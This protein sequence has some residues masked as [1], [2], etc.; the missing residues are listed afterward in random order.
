MTQKKQETKK[1]AGPE[2]KEINDSAVNS[3]TDNEMNALLA[4]LVDSKYWNAILRYTRGIDA[5]TL[6]S[7]ASLDPFKEPT[8]VARSQGLRMGLYHLE[9]TAFRE[10]EERKALENTSEK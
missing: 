4:Q 5:G 10:Y 7:L 1:E 8:L 9:Q 6:N 2:P 3:I